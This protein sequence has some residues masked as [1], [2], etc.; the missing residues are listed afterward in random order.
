M[1]VIVIVIT[2]LMGGDDKRLTAE[3]AQS[4]RD[5]RKELVE[6]ETKLSGEAEVD[7]EAERALYELEYVD[8]HGVQLV[9]LRLRLLGAEE[10]A[11]IGEH[12]RNAARRVEHRHRD[13]HP[14]ELVFAPVALHGRLLHQIRA[15]QLHRQLI[16]R[17]VVVVC[18][19]GRLTAHLEQIAAVAVARQ[20][21]WRHRVA[22]ACCAV[23]VFGDDASLSTA[24]QTVS[25]KSV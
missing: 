24:H 14:R 19:R 2:M 5:A 12:H 16:R 20:R 25:S 18:G 22:A 11:R 17:V 10:Q 8:E 1:I 3:R 7:E 9:G 15:D 21:R 6:L 23:K 4:G 13:G